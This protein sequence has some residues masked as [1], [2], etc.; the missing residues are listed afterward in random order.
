MENPT[1]QL[2]K[3][4]QRSPLLRDYVNKVQSLE[5][6]T[7]SVRQHLEPELAKNCRVANLINNVL[8]LATTSPAWNHRLRFLIPDLLNKLRNS[9]Q[10]YGLSSIEI[11]QQVTIERVDFQTNKLNPIRL[12]L[13]NAQQIASTAE[14]ITNKAL[15]KA[16]RKI[17]K[18]AI[19]E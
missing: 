3:I 9:P 7:H 2:T 4:F 13:R 18:H 14:Q 6:L 19:K 5:T 8:I 1:N 10:Y 12:S 11:I 15:A 17:A 16:L